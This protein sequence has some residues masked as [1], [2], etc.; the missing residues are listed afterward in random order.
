MNNRVTLL[1]SRQTLTRRK[2]RRT[3][4]R[5]LGLVAGL[6]LGAAPGCDK[7]DKKPQLS[8]RSTKTVTLPPKPV[9]KELPYKVTHA[10]GALTIE[11]IM[12][13]RDD[14]IGKDVKV[15]GIIE[16]LVQC[17]EPPPPPPPPPV[18]PFAPQQ[19]DAAGNPVPPPEPPPP[20]R[21][22]RTCNPP[23]H[24][25]LKDATPVSKRRLLVY[26]SMWSK[27]ENFKMG[28]SVTVEGRFD[29]VSRDGVFLRQAGLVIMPD[30]PPPEPVARPA[31][32]PTPTP[33]PGTAPAP[34]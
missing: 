3:S 34:K 24:A 18:D 19:L 21:R 14:H 12:R 25:Y 28:D 30:L 17:P 33:A 15:R 20:P 29:I 6:A 13:G 26:G 23:P 7:Q 11:G 22:P 4:G 2:P 32:T 10:D 27:L 9:L 1:G 8:E 31:A 5:L 16:K